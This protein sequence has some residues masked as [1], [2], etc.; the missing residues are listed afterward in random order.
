MTTYVLHLYVTGQTQRSLRAAANLRRICEQYLGDDYEL[1]V[2]DIQ[3]QPELAEAANIF[4]TPATLRIAPL[5]MVR[6]IGD[7]SDAAMVLSALGIEPIAYH[8]PEER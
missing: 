6:A 7:L 8:D 2:I 1:S 4:A 5:P 3:A